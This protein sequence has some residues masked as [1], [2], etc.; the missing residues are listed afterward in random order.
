MMSIQHGQ[1]LGGTQTDHLVADDWLHIDWFNWL[2]RLWGWGNRDWSGDPAIGRWNRYS[3]GDGNS[4]NSDEVGELHD[5]VEET[6][7]LVCGAGRCS[8]FV[9]CFDDLSA[10]AGTYSYSRMPMA[11]TPLS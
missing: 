8:W 11:R 7:I 9:L 3:T 6:W 10:G 4:K 2:H 5:E 1:V